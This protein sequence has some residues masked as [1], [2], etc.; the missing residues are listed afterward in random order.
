MALARL[1]STEHVWCA[2]GVLKIEWRSEGG[3]GFNQVRGE[4]TVKGDEIYKTGDG[5]IRAREHPEDNDRSAKLDGLQTLED[6]AVT[7][8][9]SSPGTR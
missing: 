4:N 5:G 1:S 7:A 2:L 8:V 6:L 9:P 3:R